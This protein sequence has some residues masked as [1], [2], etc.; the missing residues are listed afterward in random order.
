MPET[1]SK[2]RPNAAPRPHPLPAENVVSALGTDPQDGLSANEAA[3]R[4]AASGANRLHEERVTPGWQIFLR[5]FQDFMIY[6]LV[7]AVAIAAWQGDV[8]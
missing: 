4:L 7:G 8:I 2:P 1:S 6:V 5:Q 3:T